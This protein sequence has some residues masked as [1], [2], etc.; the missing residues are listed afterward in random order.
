V[1]ADDGLG[2]DQN[3]VSAP[4]GAAALGEDPE[5]LVAGV[6]PRPL[7]GRAGQD[8]ELVAQQQVL[9]DQICPRAQ[10]RPEK[11]EQQRE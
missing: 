11:R 1:P 6:Q 5:K 7:A 4:G 2:L 10:R 8:R 3:E 9:R